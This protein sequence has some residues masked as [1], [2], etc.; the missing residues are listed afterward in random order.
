MHTKGPKLNTTVAALALRELTAM[1]EVRRGAK[2]A[3][4]ENN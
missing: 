2:S 4:I 1:H 3:L